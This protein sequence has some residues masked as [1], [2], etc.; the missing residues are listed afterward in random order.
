MR[1]LA[2][3]FVIVGLPLVPRVSQAAE[4]AQVT[5]QHDPQTDGLSKTDG[6]GLPPVK[7]NDAG[8]TSN[9]GTG[10]DANGAPTATV[11]PNGVKA[12]ENRASDSVPA[13]AA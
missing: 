11:G 3:T 2:F 6:A 4:H 10:T 9:G 13:E 1:R 12:Q 8:S 7:A 5:Q